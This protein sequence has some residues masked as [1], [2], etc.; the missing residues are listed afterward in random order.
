MCYEQPKL[1]LFYPYSIMD[2][3]SYF[4]RGKVVCGDKEK[5][6]YILSY[7]VN[8]VKDSTKIVAYEK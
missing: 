5:D 1:Q 8:G 3:I 2:S 6:D 4:I 7:V